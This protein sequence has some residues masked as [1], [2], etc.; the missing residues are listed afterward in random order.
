MEEEVS[1]VVLRSD[2]TQYNS[3][4][5]VTTDT[6]KI[7]AIRI[8]IGY[9]GLNN[10]CSRSSPTSPMLV[11]LTSSEHGHGYPFRYTGIKRV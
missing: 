4:K 10:T 1:V 5:G 11:L 3:W 2:N 9:V 8:Y 7:I 6:K